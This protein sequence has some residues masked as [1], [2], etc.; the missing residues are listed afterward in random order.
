M[1]YKIFTV[2]EALKTTFDV[3]KLRGRVILVFI[4]I[5]SDFFH[6]FCFYHQLDLPVNFPEISKKSTILDWI[7]PEDIF[8]FKN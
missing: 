7:L 5:W 1:F 8:L 4:I 3:A 6:P 2:K